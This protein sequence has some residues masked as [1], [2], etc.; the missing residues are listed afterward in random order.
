MTRSGDGART[1]GQA[2]DE[3]GQG[4]DCTGWSG[5]RVVHQSG[6]EQRP[7]EQRAGEQPPQCT[8]LTHHRV[9]HGGDCSAGCSSSGRRGRW[10]RAADGA[11]AP[12]PAGG[13]K[14]EKE[15]LR[16]E[17]QRQRK[18]E[19]ALEVLH[20]AVELMEET[21]GARG[22]RGRGGGGDAGYGQA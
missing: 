7:G 12:Q 1:A 19:E 6:G 5:W 21:P 10:R 9:R 11:R 13:G 14:K 20:G 4:Q 17:R 15:R 8:S 22:V 16:K 3:Q 2:A 18:I